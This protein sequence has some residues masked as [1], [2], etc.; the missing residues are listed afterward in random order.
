MGEVSPAEFV[1]VLEAGGDIDRVG[2]WVLSQAC[3][4]AARW[5]S[6]GHP[7]RV[8]VNVSPVQLRNPEFEALVGEA[9]AESGLP[10]ALLELELTEGSM[11]DNPVATRRVL[12][13][14]HQT[15]VRVAVDD[16]GTGYASLSYVRRFPMD[17]LKIDREFVRGLPIDSE[18]VAI[19]SAICALGQ[20][21]RLD[22][23]AE[24]IESEAEE[25]FLHSLGCRV[26][27]GFRHAKPMAPQDLTRWRQKRPWA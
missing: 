16:F 25:E 15:G 23:V 21:L 9:L 24:G 27:Q 10:A 8:G 12:E 22:I 20:S 11:V 14:L 4:Q 1:P 19:T 18:N 2:R 17:T 6:E 26:V 3:V 7:L 5:A 13:S